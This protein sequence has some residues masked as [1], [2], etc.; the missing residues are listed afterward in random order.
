MWSYTIVLKLFADD[1]KVYSNVNINDISSSLQLSPDKLVDWTK[2]CQLSINIRKR[3]VLSLSHKPEQTMQHVWALDI[4]QHP[5]VTCYQIYTVLILPVGIKT[6]LW[7]WQ[8]YGHVQNTVR[9]V[10]S[11]SLPTSDILT[12]LTTI[13]W[14]ASGHHVK[15]RWRTLA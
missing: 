10:V 3:E 13:N 15:A 8:P 14:T 4:L 5:H 6:T 12:D 2:E 9:V 1:A 7:H 11:T